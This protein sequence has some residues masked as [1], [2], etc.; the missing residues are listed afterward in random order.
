M[1]GRILNPLKVFL[2]LVC[3]AVSPISSLSAATNQ[4]VLNVFLVQNSGWMEPFYEDSNSNF[5][6]LVGAV[7]NKVSGKGGEV[8]V[9]SFNQSEGANLSPL[10]AYRGSDQNVLQKELN[11]IN[12]AKK[13]GGHAY[14]DTDFKEAVI[15]SITQY[16][17]KKPCI[18]WIFTNN[19]NSPNNSPQTAA[20]N[21]D[22]YKWLKSEE[23]IKRII[24]YPYPMPV[25]GTHFNA[26]GI[27]IYAMAYGKL[28]DDQLQ[29][30][31]AAKLPFEDRP[32][33][34]KPL[35]SD[36]VT[37]VPTSVSKQNNF[38]AS[39][40]ADRNTLILL[41]N[42][43][44]K[45]AMAVINGVFRNDFFPY[46]ITSADVSL[47]VKFR[48]EDHGIKADIEPHR[49]VSVISGKQ[50]EKVSVKI[51][52]PPLPSIWSHPEI[53]FKSG[54]QS[55][56]VM[57]FTLANQSLEISQDF[58]QRMNILF[59]GDPLSEIFI[60]DDSARQSITV[61]PLLVKVE[62]PVWPLIILILLALAIIFIGAWFLSVITR[63]KKFTVVVNGM[64]KT[65]ALKAFG[66]CALYADKGSHIGT[67]KRGLGKP[68]VKLENG[69]KDQVSILN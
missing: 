9:A 47:D 68:T 56:A 51:A 18:V 19:K 61:R 66:E 26:N 32:A 57:V 29:K 40:G 67:L 12:L 4:P 2:L 7:I 13:Q 54:Y 69:C 17:P 27:M 45:P 23:N 21:K 59:P 6:P 63:A 64:Q 39:L 16:S 46:N 24:A 10:L 53:I 34:L 42:S 25:K 1:I 22:F 43:S 58:I 3:I 50:S 48:N 44:T 20:K 65:Y 30:L 5:K 62:Y 38:T 33:R 52:I 60:P 31:L 8:V 28:A 15:S 11:N 37:F 55:S 14:T 41:F 36:A 49:L 35:N